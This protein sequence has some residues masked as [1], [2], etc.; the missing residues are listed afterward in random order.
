MKYRTQTIR[1]VLF[2]GILLYGATLFGLIF[3]A[4]AGAGNAARWGSGTP[5]MNLQKTNWKTEISTALA[6][7]DT[8]VFVF[9]VGDDQTLKNPYLDR[10]ERYYRAHR[11]DLGGANL[12]V[13]RRA[14][15]LSE[16]LALLRSEYRQHGTCV[17]RLII[18]AHGNPWSGLRCPVVKARERLTPE[19]L[20]RALEQRR[21]RP[22]EEEL[23]LKGAVIEIR[24][25]GAGRIRGL[26]TALKKLFPITQKSLRLVLPKGY[27]LYL[28]ESSGSRSLYRVNATPWT[29]FY[30]SG[31]YPGEIRLARKFQRLFGRRLEWRKA[32]KR[33]GFAPLSFPFSLE[34][35]IPVEWIV[36]YPD[37]GRP[38]V[39][40]IGK[41]MSWLKNRRD[42]KRYLAR[43][44]LNLDQ[45]TWHVAPV[46]RSDGAGGRIPA[47]RA[48][49]MTTAV[50]ILE[51]DG[52]PTHSFQDGC[53][54]VFIR[55]PLDIAG[56]PRP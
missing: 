39:T 40:T 37:G 42:L 28:P 32:L 26:R 50:T 9:I 24:G 21:I 5:Q 25:C 8:A 36:L 20:Q 4:L 6:P 13:V 2:G 12:R 53:F 41:Q 11:A 52:H 10:A 31:Y 30:P 29:V 51:P 17:G 18:V 16:I 35:E 49:G 1:S 34:Y 3:S 43:R 45:F 22:A 19:T 33:R 7:A 54:S 46:Q 44:G 55:S 23:F 15:S 56:I 27:E 48:L 38:S 14:Q 47:I